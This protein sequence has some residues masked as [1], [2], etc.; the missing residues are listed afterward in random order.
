MTR[1]Q[2]VRS[3]FVALLV[4]IVYQ[5]FLIFL[6]FYQSIFWAAIL[7]FA[8]FPLYFKIRKWLA[9]HETLAAF[10]STLVV[11]LVVIPPLIYLAINVTSQAIQLY[12]KASD[13]VRGGHLE[14]LVDHIRSLQLV[15]SVQS[16]TEIWTPIKDNLGDWLLR[17][18]RYLGD[19]TAHQ[20]AVITKNILFIAVNFFLTAILMFI[21]FKDGEKIYNFVYQST[22]LE[23]QHKNPI[24]KQINDTFTAVIRGQLLT[25][26]AQATISGFIFWFLGIPLPLLFAVALFFAAL[27]PIIGAAGI[28]VPLVF[29]LFFSVHQTT[30]AVILLVFGIL[31]IS[32]LDNIIK[33]AIIGEKTKLPYFLLFFGILGGLRVYGLLGIF[34]APVV[35]SLFFALVSIYQEKNW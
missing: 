23:E 27:I 18:S 17:S 19:Y 35:L 1:D 28:W 30:K 2:F 13:Y 32:L 6:P 9:P 16:R 10:L 34:L 7:T 26:V 31:V 15:K 5:L 8:F 14:E 3:F 29:Y 4:F 20:I 24:F 21:F 33:P 22:P 11:V 25:A 12:Q